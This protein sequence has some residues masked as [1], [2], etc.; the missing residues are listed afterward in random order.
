MAGHGFLHVDVVI[1]DL[2][3]SKIILVDVDAAEFSVFIGCISNDA[4]EVTAKVCMNLRTSEVEN[5]TIL[6]GH[7]ISSCHAQV[8]RSFKGNSKVI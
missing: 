7:Q 6:M 1:N 3:E 4:N 5:K 2:E 8:V